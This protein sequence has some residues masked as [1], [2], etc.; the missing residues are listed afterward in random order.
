MSLI[1][2]HFREAGKRFW[3]NSISSAAL[4]YRLSWILNLIVPLILVFRSDGLWIKNMT[5][6]EQPDINFKHQYLIILDVVRPFPGH[7]I[8]STFPQFND[9]FEPQLIRAPQVSNYETDYNYDGV[10]DDLFLELALPLKANEEVSAIDLF[11]MFDYKLRSKVHF[12]MEAVVR[13]SYRSMTTGCKV[14]VTGDLRLNQKELLHAAHHE[15]NFSH[16]LEN[17]MNEASSSTWSLEDLM[18]DYLKRNVTSELSSAAY[19]KWSTGRDVS[20]DMFNMTVRLNYAPQQIFYRPGFWF[21]IKWAWIQYV[22]VFVVLYYL[23]QK[24]RQIVFEQH[25]IPTV[26]CQD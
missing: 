11:L 4:F 21:V 17:I 3:T 23:I 2:V 12:D 6:E 1:Q 14:F 18:H 13:I 10:Y 8:H 26:H 20:T 7:L 22:S 15:H 5:I 24:V 9:L 16:R 19:I 25:L